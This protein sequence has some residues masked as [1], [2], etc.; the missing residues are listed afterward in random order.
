MLICKAIPATFM[1]KLRDRTRRGLITC[2][3]TEYPQDTSRMDGLWT[4]DC[5]R[6]IE[7]TI[8]LTAVGREVTLNRK[9]RLKVAHCVYVKQENS[10]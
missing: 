8:S 6:I 1:R 3:L 9:G 4:V 7:L 10:V 5:G 2:L